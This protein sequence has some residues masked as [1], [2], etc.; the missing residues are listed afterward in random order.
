MN[1]FDRQSCQQKFILLTRK[2][3]ENLNKNVIIG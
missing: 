3:T 2:L 1:D